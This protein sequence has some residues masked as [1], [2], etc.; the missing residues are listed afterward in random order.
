[1]EIHTTNKVLVVFLQ[2][3]FTTKTK[4]SVKN[5]YHVMHKKRI[6]TI[7]GQLARY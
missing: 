3:V 6:R 4:T 7:Q 2:V 5:L 1:M